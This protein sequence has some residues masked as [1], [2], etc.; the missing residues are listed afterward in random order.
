MLNYLSKQ[1]GDR[2][3]EDDLKY[4]N[5][6]IRDDEIHHN[7]EMVIRVRGDE[8]RD[9]DDNLIADIRD[10]SIIKTG[11]FST[12]TYNFNY[13]TNLDKMKKAQMFAIAE[14]L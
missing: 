7:G 3:Y 11:M 5:Y 10:T 14:E 9:K 2:I 1:N 12:T 13:D 4:S 8:I 6:S